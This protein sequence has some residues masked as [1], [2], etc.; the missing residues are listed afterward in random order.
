MKIEAHNNVV[1]SLNQLSGLEDC[2]ESSFELL[3]SPELPQRQHH[4]VINELETMGNILGEVRKKSNLLMKK[5]SPILSL[6][7]AQNCI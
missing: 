1:A 5:L 3:H 4:K 6:T 2:I 7:Y